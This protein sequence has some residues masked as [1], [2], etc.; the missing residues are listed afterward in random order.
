[1]SHATVSKLLLEL[2]TGIFNTLACCLDVVD[3]DARVTEPAV[4]LFVAVLHRVIG[5]IL[6]TVVVGELI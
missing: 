6:S 3:T 2:V 1:M 5:I 4:R